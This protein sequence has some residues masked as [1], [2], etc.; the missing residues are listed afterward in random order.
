M[1]FKI[2][3]K[4]I[5]FLR[6]VPLSKGVYTRNV[7]LEGG[8]GW[9]CLKIMINDTDRGVVSEYFSP[10]AYKVIYTYI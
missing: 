6:L 1:I 9:R 5:N 7:K 2:T 8:A 3:R 10:I 4:H